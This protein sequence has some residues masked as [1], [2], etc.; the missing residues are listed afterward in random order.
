TKWFHVAS[1][2]S[3]NIV[4]DLK[5]SQSREAV[6]PALYK[7][8]LP[9][10]GPQHGPLRKAVVSFV[11]SHW[12][13]GHFVAVEYER[14]VGRAGP[15][16]WHVTFGTL[17]DDVLLNIFRHYLDD[18]PR[19]WHTL[20]KVCR[21]WR[22]IVFTSP[23][24]LDLRLRC[25]YGTPVLKTLDC[26]PAL[27]II[28]QNGRASTLD[29]PTT[30]DEDNIVAALKHSDRVYSI[31]LTIPTSLPAKL[32]AIEKPF[33]KLEELVLQSPD[34]VQL[35]FPN[36]LRWGTRL[37]TLHSTRIAFP[38]LPRLLSSSENL[39]DLRLHEIPSSGY[40]SPKVFADALSGMIQL[41]SLSLHF[42]SPASRP[43]H[44][45]ISPLPGGRV[46]LPALS[47][48]KFKGTSEYLN[49]L[50]TRVDAP[51]LEDIEVRF[52][53]QLIFHISQLC[54]FVDRIEMQK[55]HRLADILP[56]EHAIVVVFGQPN[57]RVWL[58]LQIS[59]EQLDWQLSSVA[60]ICDQFSSSGFLIGVEDL[61]INMTQS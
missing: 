25:T 1:D 14:L 18:S 56:S 35:T 23:P 55:S 20:T 9:Q 21:R 28:I 41:Q 59:C 10:P 46:V 6:L 36:T 16:S 3:T 31:S 32:F 52:F 13:S 4:F 57:A 5:P 42:L 60:Q 40:L 2:Q 50:V 43:S 45:G 33:S 26:W 49:D 39:V 27:P 48:F 17:S 29:P 11:H 58:R 30:E 44:A 24:G 12:P 51:R 22:Q 37:R 34:N 54:C 19:F 53:N 38:A 7:L 47:R 8:Y 61:R 15:F